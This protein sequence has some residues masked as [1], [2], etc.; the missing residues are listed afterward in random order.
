MSKPNEKELLNAI[1]NRVCKYCQNYN[2][3]DY[4]KPCLICNVSCCCMT[5]HLYFEDKNEQ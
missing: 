1:E 5:I 4:S 2:N 3:G